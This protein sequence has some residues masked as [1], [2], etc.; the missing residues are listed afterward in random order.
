MEEERKPALGEIDAFLPACGPDLREANGTGIL[1]AFGNGCNDG[2][3]AL[4]PQIVDNDIDAFAVLI[5]YVAGLLEGLLC[6]VTA[7]SSPFGCEVIETAQA[8]LHTLT[9]MSS[10]CLSAS[11]RKI[12]LL[13]QS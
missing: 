1:D 6:R 5:N 7:L 8:T 13:S 9:M 2:P 4:S 10:G 11:P 12:D 3:C